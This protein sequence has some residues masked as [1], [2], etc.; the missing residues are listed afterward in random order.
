MWFV[1]DNFIAD[2][3]CSHVLK[4]PAEMY[5]KNSFELFTFCSSRRSDKNAN[6]ISRFRNAIAHGLNTR[7]RVPKYIIVIL[8]VDFL[9]YLNFTGC[10][11]STMMG[12]WIES[13]AAKINEYC[14][15]RKT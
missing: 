5:V 1:G 6:P 7:I 4:N 15:A 2:T 13:S 12:E 9:E 8:D 11:M 10:G 3:Y 14:D